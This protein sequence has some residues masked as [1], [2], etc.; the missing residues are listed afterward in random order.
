MP[1]QKALCLDLKDEADEERTMLLISRVEGMFWRG[2][3]RGRR[4]WEGRGRREGEV[5]Y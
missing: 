4:E 5:R 2:E 3:G 1:I